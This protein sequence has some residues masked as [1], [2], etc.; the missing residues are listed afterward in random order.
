MGSRSDDGLRR[1]GRVAVRT[2]ASVA[3]LLGTAAPLRAQVVEGRLVD[4]ARGDPIALGRVALLDTTLAVVDLDFTDD[5]GTF[6]LAG[7][8]GAYFV[9]GD[10]LGFR[11]ALDG[12]FEL[13]ADAYLPVDF[14]LEPNPIEIEGITATVERQ[15]IERHLE[16]AGFYDRRG[17]GF[18]HFI[19]PDEIEERNPIDAQ[20]LVRSVPGVRVADDGIFG[21]TVYF[22]G[23]RGD[24]C[25][26][27]MYVDGMRVTGGSL[28]DIVDVRDI[29]A[30]ELFTRATSLPL[31]YGGTTSTCGALLLWTKRG[32]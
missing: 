22:R 28:D 12:I 8:P 11:S 25:T 20:D 30:V 23:P 24:Y 7:P 15:R 5:E 19:G 16:L 9:A 26:P 18:G 29:A 17:Q 6:R 14:R 13:G 10:A 27:Q 3:V 4:G 32:G 1:A 2:L 21:E 31:Q